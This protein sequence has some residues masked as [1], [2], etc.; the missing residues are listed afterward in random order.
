M[1]YV[2]TSGGS[3]MPVNFKADLLGKNKKQVTKVKVKAPGKTKKRS[4][5]GSK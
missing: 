2:R 4:L 3:M 1:H 5:F